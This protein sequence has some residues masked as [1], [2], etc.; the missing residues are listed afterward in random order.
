MRTVI[1][2]LLIPLGAFA[3]QDVQF[4]QYAFNTLA[5]NPAYA[6]YRGAPTLNATFRDQWAGFSGAPKT[7]TLSLDGLTSAEGHTGLGVQLLYDQLGPQQNYSL[8]G[9]YA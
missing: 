6:G 2:L 3:Q 7:A 4:S 8:T 1:L 9:F 5:L